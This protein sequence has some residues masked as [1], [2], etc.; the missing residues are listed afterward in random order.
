MVIVYD[1]RIVLL[2]GSLESDEIG[3]L[4]FHRCK[5]RVGRGPIHIRETNGAPASIELFGGRDAPRIGIE[6]QVYLNRATGIDPY[7]VQGGDLFCAPHDLPPL[8]CSVTEYR[9]TGGIHPP[10]YLLCRAVP[11]LQLLRRGDEVP[12]LEQA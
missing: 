5:G 11:A 7:T 2:A 4:G 8:R 6:G 10:E 3:P 12:F 9:M 1:G